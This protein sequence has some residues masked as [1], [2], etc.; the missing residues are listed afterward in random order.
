MATKSKKTIYPDFHKDYEE[1]MGVELHPDTARE[2]MKAEWAGCI[3]LFPPDVAEANVIETSVFASYLLSAFYPFDAWLAMFE[4]CIVP[5]LTDR[6]VESVLDIN[7]GFPYVAVGCG[8]LGGVRSFVCEPRGRLSMFLQCEMAC[9]QLPVRYYEGEGVDVVV[10]TGG[11]N[12][13][14]EPQALLKRIDAALQPGGLLI[15]NT[16][17]YLMIYP[18]DP[19]DRE[20]QWKSYIREMGYTDLGDNLFEKSKEI[21]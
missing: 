21:K 16:L 14:R 5:I 8:R 15:V 3:D 9:R 2:S 7:S 17:P 18:F 19:M 20:P 4:N 1:I 12:T 11:L 10:T 6:G 13:T